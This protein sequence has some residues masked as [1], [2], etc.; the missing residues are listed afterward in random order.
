MTPFLPLSFLAQYFHL[1]AHGFSFSPDNS[2]HFNYFWQNRTQFRPLSPRESDDCSLWLIK[3]LTGMLGTLSGCVH[4]AYFSWKQYIFLWARLQL[5][6]SVIVFGCWRMHLSKFLHGKSTIGRR[7]QW[8]GNN[9]SIFG[10]FLFVHMSALEEVCLELGQ[11][12]VDS[13]L[14]EPDRFPTLMFQI[15]TDVLFSGCY[16]PIVRTMLRG[17]SNLDTFLDTHIC[18][19]YSILHCAVPLSL[20][21]YL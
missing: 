11:M 6:R 19:G 14:S 7:G 8:H 15:I 12:Q 10:L 4:E 1:S 5:Q 21:V 13:S 17:G 2:H 3:Y 20:H 16:E 9:F 18:D